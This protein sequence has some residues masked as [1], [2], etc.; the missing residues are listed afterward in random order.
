[1]ARKGINLSM[2][3]ELTNIPLQRLST[4]L[5]GKRKL[6]FDEAVLIKA[7]L[8]LDMPLDELFAKKEV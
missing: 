7:K 4:K 5:S 6:T 8:G 1:M 2:L 3:S